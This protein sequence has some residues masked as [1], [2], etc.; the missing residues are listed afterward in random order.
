MIEKRDIGQAVHTSSE[1]IVIDIIVSS[2]AKKQELKGY[3][4]WRKR[5]EIAIYSPPEKGKANQEVLRFFEDL[6]GIT[7]GHINISKGRT[8]RS[9]SLLIG[10]GVEVDEPEV[11]VET[12]S[13]AMR[14]S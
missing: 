7:K 4:P 10:K 6:L 11:V 2:G 3:N 12:I 13:N 8:S 5:I 1:G 14:Q 9:K